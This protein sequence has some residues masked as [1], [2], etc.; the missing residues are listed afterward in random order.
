MK[1]R[2]DD[3]DDHFMAHLQESLRTFKIKR[4]EVAATANTLFT[5]DNDAGSSLKGQKRDA[6]KEKPK[7]V[8][9]RSP[10]N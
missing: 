4:A 7:N 3:N 2:V 8:K 10:K 5:F 6:Q 1:A 9:V